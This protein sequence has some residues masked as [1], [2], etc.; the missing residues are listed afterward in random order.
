ML[1]NT[2]LK[3]RV[4][5][6]I[7]KYSEVE[8]VILYGSTVRGKKNPKDVDILVLFHQKVD[9]KTEYEIRKT[10]EK[11]YDNVSIISKTAATVLE[12]AFD[13]RESVLFEGKSFL[14]GK[15]LGEKY[16]FS[17]LGM[18]KYDFKGWNNTKRTKFYYALNG[19]GKEKGI[20]QKLQC[21][22][23]SDRVVLVP[24]DHIELFREFLESWEME[25]RYVPMLL[26]IRLNRRKI[27][28]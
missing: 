12:S 15:T 28:E 10:I 26:P 3:N 13:A 17:S 11:D 22:K 5:K 7:S 18:F 25:Y 20:S 6:L 21:I 23:Y 19:R 14:T 9:K 1:P 8:D 24:L 2:K 27:L 16:G 4:K